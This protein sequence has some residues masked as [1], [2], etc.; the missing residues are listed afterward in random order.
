[1]RIVLDT[2]VLIAAL[3]SQGTCADLLEQCVI[4]HELITSEP[5]LNELRVNLAG[6]FKFLKAE[7]E[8][9]VELLQSQMEVVIPVP[10]V[11]PVCRDVDDDMVI[12]TALAGAAGFVITGDKD[13][14]LES[15]ERIRMVSPRQFTDLE[16]ELS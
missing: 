9:A 4:H 15:Y 3:I 5:I 11:E 16:S 2:N 7:A 6:K 14:L 1:M 12:G 8:E 13:L 10:L